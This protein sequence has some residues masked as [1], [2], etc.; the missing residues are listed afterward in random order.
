MSDQFSHA[1]N[2]PVDPSSVAI[3]VG[4]DGHGRPVSMTDGGLL[5]VKNDAPEPSTLVDVSEYRFIT[6]PDGQVV[7]VHKSQI[8]TAAIA[9]DVQDA[10][11]IQVATVEVRHYYVHLANGEVKRVT[12]VDLPPSG[13]IEAPYGHWQ[14]DN[15]VHLIIGVYP[16]EIVKGV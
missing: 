4:V 14:S 16:V 3:A 7:P 11:P 5:T 1:E 10:P 12:E 6:M 9:T 15:K 8:E 2:T 13:G